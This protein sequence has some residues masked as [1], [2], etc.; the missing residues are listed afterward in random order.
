MLEISLSIRVW[1]IEKEIKEITIKRE[2]S[3]SIRVWNYFAGDILALYH[4]EISLS[5][6]VWNYPPV[7]LCNLRMAKLVYL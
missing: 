5:I 4:I 1:N 2:I 6:R 3:L 7:A